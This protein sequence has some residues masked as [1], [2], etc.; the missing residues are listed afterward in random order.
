[1]CALPLM[2]KGVERI[3]SALCADYERRSCAIRDGRVGHRTEIEYRYLNYKILDAA[4]D[5]VGECEAEIFIREIGLG[6]GYAKS[7]H[8]FVSESAYKLRKAAVKL[9]IARALHLVD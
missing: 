2:D 9:S 6:T 5:A 1:M 4:R 8:T 3:V 7:G